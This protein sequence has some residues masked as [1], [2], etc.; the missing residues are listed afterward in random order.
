MPVGLMRANEM[1]ESDF[2]QGP[3]EHRIYDIAGIGR[4]N[5]FYSSDMMDVEKGVLTGVRIHTKEGGSITERIDADEA[6]WNEEK[7]RWYLT[8]GVIRK[9]DTNGVIVE[10]TPFTNMKARLIKTRCCALTCN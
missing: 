4:R 10:T 6:V 7:G 2:A 8:S 1:R 3:R 9:F 5:R